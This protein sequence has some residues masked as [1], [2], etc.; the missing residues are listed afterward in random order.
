MLKRLMGGIVREPA[1][2]GL[3]IV[4]GCSAAM[5]GLFGATLSKNLLFGA[6]VGTA[7]FG[8]EIVKWRAPFWLSDGWDRRQPMTVLLASL[9]L[10]GCVAIS[11]TSQLGFIGLNRGDAVAAR[12]TSA[13]TR[14]SFKAQAAAARI[15]VTTAQAEEAREIS[16]GGCGPRCL[17]ARSKKTAAQARLDRALAGLAGLKQVGRS[18]PAIAP[19][20]WW[21]PA[22][23]DVDLMTGLII[24][25]AVAVEL[26]TTSG[27]W[28]ARGRGFDGRLDMVSA[29]RQGMLNHPQMNHVLVWQADCLRQRWGAR[30]PVSDVY[31]AYRRWGLQ[32]GRHAV[33]ELVFREMLGRIVRVRDQTMIGHVVRPDE[34]WEAEHQATALGIVEGEAA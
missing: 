7:W 12:D 30:V 33:G 27:F 28:L 1:L 16:A 9:V 17:A 23:S 18:D 4:A 3:W 32:T 6:I 10:I 31:A 15:D 22:W 24:L 25:L 29:V 2:V 8:S 19:L 11:F 21:W 34:D 5:N 20:K 14:Q 13:T 26:M